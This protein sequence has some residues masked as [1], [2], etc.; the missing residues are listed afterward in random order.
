MMFK[1]SEKSTFAYWFAH[2]CAYQMTALNYKM[3]RPKYLLHDIEKPWLMLLWNDYPRVK[4]WHR[5][6]AD[7]HLEHVPGKKY[8]WEAMAID[9]E[10][11]RFTKESAQMNVRDTM[12][13]EEEKFPELKDEIRSNISKVLLKMGL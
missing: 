9:W 4:A 8:D 3:W 5:S 10:C 11:S 2:W 1:E 6:H 13:Y 12:I 7:H